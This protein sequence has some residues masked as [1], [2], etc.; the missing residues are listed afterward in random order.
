MWPAC[1]H[2]RAD[3]R[4]RRARLMVLCSQETR[5]GRTGSY[6]R[7]GLPGKA[8]CK[9]PWFKLT[10]PAPLDEYQK[11]KLQ[12]QQRGTWRTR[13]RDDHHNPETATRN[14]RRLNPKPKTLNPKLNLQAS[15]PKTNRGTLTEPLQQPG[16]GCRVWV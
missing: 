8:L 15:T 13:N 9:D 12:Y 14:L 4:G 3:A 6:S 16:L 1:S 2:L 7:H 11:K 5:T 10:R